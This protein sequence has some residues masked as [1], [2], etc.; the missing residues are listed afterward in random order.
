MRKILFFLVLSL[1]IIKPSFCA[2]AEKN[3]DGFDAGQMIMH[4]IL[5]S[6]EWHIAD[7]KGK[8]ITI[9]LPVIIYSKERGLLF[10]M[11]SKFHNPEHTYNGIKIDHGKLTSVNGEKFY[12][13]SITKNVLSLF[14]SMVLL[15]FIF[16]SIGKKYKNNSKR[17]PGGL[18][19]FL[20]PII[21]FVKDDIVKPSIGEKEYSRFL[22]FLLT[23]FFFIW[24]NNLL[25]LIPVFPGGAN[26]TGN[27]AIPFVLATIILILT[28]ING[29]KTY[30]MHV[31]AMPGVPKWVLTILTPIEIISIFLKPLV[32]MIRLFANITAGHIIML[33]FFS[34]IFIFGDLFGNVAGYGVSAMSI[35][36]TVFMTMLELIVAFLQAY[37]FT[38]LSAMYFGSAV[39]EGHH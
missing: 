6:Y 16:I 2:A 20:E 39:E 18:Q 3:Q 36:F 33:S 15:L 29:K 14:I 24:I 1:F 19:A 22:P 10:F 30:W 9:P 38:L 23:M 35:A 28:N 8:H 26:V 13:I 37:V 34:L 7:I 5:D 21:L 31:F 11:S 27:I 4:H 17:A 25:G 32:L 12:D